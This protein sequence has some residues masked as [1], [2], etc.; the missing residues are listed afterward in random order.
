MWPASE[1]MEFSSKP[2]VKSEFF[3]CRGCLGDGQMY[4]MHQYGLAESY[5]QLVG[6]EVIL[7]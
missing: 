5:K 4:N 1:S 2:E 7:L 3:I 6:V